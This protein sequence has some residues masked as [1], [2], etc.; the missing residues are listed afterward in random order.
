MAKACGETRLKIFGD[1]NVMVQQVMNHCD[2]ISDNMKAY[3]NLYYYLEGT[4]DGCV[5]S[6]KY[7]GSCVAFLISKSVEPNEELKVG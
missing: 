5:I 1:S 4:F 7:R 3:Q 2:A 6:H